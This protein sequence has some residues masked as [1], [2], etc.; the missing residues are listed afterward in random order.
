MKGISGTL[1]A[2]IF[3]F[4]SLFSLITV[5]RTWES[6]LVPLADNESRVSELGLRFA[7]QR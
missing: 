1:L 7:F 6:S 3:V 5:N 4:F 2:L